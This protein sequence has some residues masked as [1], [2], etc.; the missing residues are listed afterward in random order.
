MADTRALQTLGRQYS[1]KI[2]ALVGRLASVLEPGERTR[3]LAQARSS[4]HFSEIRDLGGVLLA[5]TDRRLLAIES[6]SGKLEGNFRLRDLR[7]K[8][9]RPKLYRPLVTATFEGVAHRYHHVLPQRESWRL[10]QLATQKFDDPD[11][12][13]SNLP[14]GFPPESESP[15]LD[16]FQPNAGKSALYLYPDRLVVGERSMIGGRHYPF[17]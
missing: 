5:L 16:V 4:G 7:L 11:D 6:D 1:K 15:L 8:Y 10:V 12:L 3:V 9:E 14:A 13:R 2:G 17:A